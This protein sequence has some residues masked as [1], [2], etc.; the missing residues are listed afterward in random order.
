MFHLKRKSLNILINLES[1]ESQKLEKLQNIDNKSDMMKS[2]DKS[3]SQTIMQLS[4]S[5]NIFLNIF[6]R[7]KLNMLLDKEKL[8]NMNISQLKDKLFTIL[9]NLQKP[10]IQLNMDIILEVLH[11]MAMEDHQFN[12]EDIQLLLQQG[13]LLTLQLKHMQF[14]DLLHTTPQVEIL[15]L[16]KLEVNI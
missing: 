5:G 12:T 4:I 3:Q 15:L 13:Q 1:K 6:L 8:K 14:P 2:L 11:L 10:N 9:N 7:K 16:I